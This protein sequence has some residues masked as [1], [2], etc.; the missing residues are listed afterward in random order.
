MA[1]TNFINVPATKP[2]NAPNPAFNATLNSFSSISSPI[3]APTKGN[4]I[5]H[6]GG[7]MNM[8]ATTPIVLP[9]APFFPPPSFFVPHMGM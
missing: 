9:Q 2:K 8:P 6:H 7:I 3:T 1:T 4:M 5:I